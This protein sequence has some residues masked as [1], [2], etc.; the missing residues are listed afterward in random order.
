MKDLRHIEI[1]VTNHC[2]LRC[3]MCP[4]AQ[5]VRPKGFV[6]INT[7]TRAIDQV[8]GYVKTMYL[9]Q[10]GEP[11][12]HPELIA[13]IDYAN[14]AGIKTSISTN[15]LA[16]DKEMTSKILSSKLKEITLCLDSL[17]KNS[18][19][20]IRLGSNFDRVLENINYFLSEKIRTESKI[21]V[22]LQMIKMILNKSERQTFGKNFNGVDEIL[23]KGYSTFAGAVGEGEEI[24]P[25]FKCSKTCNSL[26][27]QYNGD[28]IVCCRDFNG[29][30]KLGNVNETS[31]PEIWKMHKRKDCKTIPFCSTCENNR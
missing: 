2:Q 10:I 4:Q 21:H 17:N 7:F 14:D 8:R 26:T 16:L 13:M 27:I 25:S 30:T 22:Q 24:A 23:V 1:E 9:H 15:C 18:Y 3:I 19:E 12:L 5:M 28:I 29:E 11:L 31:I 20:S 6:D